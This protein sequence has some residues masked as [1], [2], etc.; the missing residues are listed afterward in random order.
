MRFHALDSWRGIAALL[1][2]LVHL[3]A[4]GAFYEFPPVRHGGLSVPFFFVLSG[5]VISHAYGARLRN[6]AEVGQFVLRRVGRLYPL[7]IVMLGVLV[8]LELVKWVLVRHGAPSGQAPFAGANDLPSLIAN[9]F[10]LQAIVPLPDYSWNVP[11]WSISVEFYTYLIFCMVAVRARS[12]AP[13]LLIVLLSGAVLLVLEIAEPTLKETQFRGL[14]SCV[15]GF[16]A[17]HLVYHAFRQLRRPAPALATLFEVLAVMVLIGL[18]W[19]RPLEATS[20]I[21][22]F[23]GVVLVFAFDG[24]AVSRLLRGR[25]WAFLGKISY[26]IYMVHFVLLSLLG[27]IIRGAQ[28]L[29]HRKLYHDIAGTPMID[30]GPTGTMDALA[31]LYVLVVVGVATLTYRWVEMP[32]QG[33]FHQLGRRWSNAASRAASATQS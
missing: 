26:S 1:V 11:S 16:F 9:V 6:S 7:H 5:F 4:N 27:G 8:L 22:V 29:L 10:L 23:A 28:A 3:S 19:F 32:G 25:P 30:F 18:Y 15:C 2:V 21:L 33:L 20:S 31:L 13:A 24:G 14:A 17:G 12:I